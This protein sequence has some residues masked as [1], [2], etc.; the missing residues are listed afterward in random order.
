MRFSH[1][2]WNSR[3][4]N[5]QWCDAAT[6]SA[7]P[8]FSYQK[9]KTIFLRLLGKAECTHFKRFNFCS[10]FANRENVKSNINET[11]RKLKIEQS[12]RS[13]LSPTP[14]SNALPWKHRW[15]LSPQRAEKW[16]RIPYC[17]ALLSPSAASPEPR[18]QKRAFSLRRSTDSCET[19]LLIQRTQ[20][21]LCHLVAGTHV[22]FRRISTINSPFLFESMI[23]SF[24]FFFYRR[25]VSHCLLC[26]NDRSAGMTAGRTSSHLNSNLTF[27]ERFSFFSIYE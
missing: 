27:L 26:Q 7:F 8:S 14:N 13:V 2:P 6:S 16:T 11:R 4:G 15:W 25:N 9:F 21:L 1:W 10:V 3:L 23:T 17:S 18:N 19:N 12:I 5:I 22:L 20:S 24:L